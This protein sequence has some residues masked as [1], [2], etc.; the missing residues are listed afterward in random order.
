MHQ[1]QIQGRSGVVVHPDGGGVEQPGRGPHGLGQLLAGQGAD[2]GPGEQ[3]GV[4]GGPLLGAV[5]VHAAAMTVSMATIPLLAVLS[6]RVGRK[7]VLLVGA[8]G[9][10]VSVWFYFEAIHAGSW[11]LIFLLCIVNQGLFYSCWNAVWTVFF[12][13]MFAAPVRYT[14]MAMG[15]QL[16]LVLIGFAPSIAA[17]IEP[18]F[19]WQGVVAFVVVSIL[20][21]CVTI[22]TARETAFVP[23]EQLGGEAVQ[24]AVREQRRAAAEQ[25]STRT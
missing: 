5:P 18:R 8:L 9:C 12:P 1:L 4:L 17:L 15:N 14:G 25:R 7:P 23:Q 2:L 22:L 11:P 13:E 19:G 24:Q 3:P 21:S 10:I 16:G 20:I 6:D